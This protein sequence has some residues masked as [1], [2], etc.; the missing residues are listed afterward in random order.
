MAADSF[1]AFRAVTDGDS[2][3]RGVVTMSS[4][5]LP[6]DGALIEV[7]WSSVNYKDGL[8]STPT[9]KVARISPI[10]PGVDLAGVLVDDCPDCRPGHRCSRTAT[11]S[12]CHATAGS[13]STPGCRPSGWWRCRP[14]SRPAR[15]W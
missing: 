12:G 5:E 6:G 1:R 14:G 9:G 4:D 3:E 10:V 8:A 7:H 13:P 11:T 15:R 2:I